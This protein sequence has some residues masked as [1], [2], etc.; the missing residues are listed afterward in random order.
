M[1]T[2]PASQPPAAGQRP[3]LTPLPGL[4]N[5]FDMLEQ[6]PHVSRAYLI[7]EDHYLLRSDVFVGSEGWLCNYASEAG[8]APRPD[9][10]VAFGVNFPSDEITNANGYVI[11]EIGK[12]PDF[13]LEVASKSTGRRDYI[14]K[15]ATYARYRV[16]EYWRFDRTGG[17][18]HDAPLAGDRLVGDRYEP[19]PVEE[20]SDGVIRG[21]SEA[22]QLELHWY[23]GWLRFWDP[24][25]GEYLPDLTETKAQ[26]DDER[27]ARLSAETRAEDER[28]ARLSAEIR[29]EDE[30]AARLS[31]ETRAEDERAARLSIEARLR[32][33]EAELNRSQ[34]EN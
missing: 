14:A 1:T 16:S 17:Q 28:T 5:P 4:S 3:R 18:Y 10:L 32:E 15:R 27:A 30:R 11:S 13:V 9:C 33:M 31:A 12:P 25:T 26:R 22:L 34:S 2:Q 21:Y 24:A 19:I 29:A 6:V 8:R 20:G 23:R 7:L